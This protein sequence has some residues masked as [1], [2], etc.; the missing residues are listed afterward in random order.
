VNVTQSPPP[1]EKPNDA[2]TFELYKTAFSRLNFQDEYLFKFSTV[3]LTVHGALTV[4]AGTAYF[5]KTPP[6]FGALIALAMIGLVLAFAWVLW[7]NHNYYWH[8]VWIGVLRDIE[9]KRLSTSARVFAIKTADYA[10]PGLT[11]PW[12]HGHNIARLVPL[13][14]LFEWI[15]VLAVAVSKCFYAVAVSKCF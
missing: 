10:K 7:I 1:A 5:Q 8:T 15:V 3:F 12:L 9:E 4:L 13:A 6:E 2:A 14:F 11:Q